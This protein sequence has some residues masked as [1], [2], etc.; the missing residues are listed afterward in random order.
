ML[1][2]MVNH[3]SPTGNW[4]SVGKSVIW[5]SSGLLSVAGKKQNSLIIARNFSRGWLSEIIEI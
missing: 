5:D 4:K 2:A 1:A 3:N